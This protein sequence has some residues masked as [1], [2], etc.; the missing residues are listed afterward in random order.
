LNF[1]ART[2]P[3]LLDAAFQVVRARFVAL[4][5]ATVAITFPAM[6]VGLLLPEWENLGTL[7]D[8]QQ[9]NLAAAVVVLIVSD[10]YLGRDADLASVFRRALARFGSIVGAA[11]VQTLAIILGVLLCIIPGIIATIVTFA[12]P[13]AVVLEGAG[14][15]QAYVRSN[16]L[17][18]GQWGRITVAYLLILVLGIAVVVGSVAVGRLAGGET[19]SRIVGVLV[20]PVFSMFTAVIGTLLYYDIRIRKEAFDIEMLLSEV[21]A[22]SPAPAPVREF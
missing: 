10:A 8:Y 5:L 22:L 4:I 19:A 3:E 2:V 20:D 17:A 13:M 18:R 7:F 9:R 11:L 21:D 15:I 14:G 1:R 16:E 6:V 12:M